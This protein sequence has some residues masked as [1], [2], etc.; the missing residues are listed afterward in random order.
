MGR[1]IEYGEQ[2][3]MPLTGT[4]PVLQL[5]ALLAIDPNCA[6]TNGSIKYNLCISDAFASVWGNKA[7]GS[8][9]CPTPG[10]KDI[11]VEIDYMENHAPEHRRYKECDKG[12]WECASSKLSTLMA[13]T[14]NGI[15]PTV[16]RLHVVV[17][18]QFGRVGSIQ[19]LD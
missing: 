19:C 8:T 10:H 11:Y 15:I 1:S 14:P 7:D 18:D 6:N 17:S 5:L 16:L 2:G 13:F 3:T 4:L 12:I 9:I